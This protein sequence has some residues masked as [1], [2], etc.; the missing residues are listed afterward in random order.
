MT[1]FHE[2]Q[3]ATNEC[4]DWKRCHERGWQKHGEKNPSHVCTCIQENCSTRY[5]GKQGNYRQKGVA[6]KIPR[7][8][9]RELGCTIGIVDQRLTKVCAG[10]KP[11]EGTDAEQAWSSPSAEH[12]TVV[13]QAGGSCVS[14]YSKAESSPS[15]AYQQ[16][17]TCDFYHDGDIRETWVWWSALYPCLVIGF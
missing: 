7:Y 1:D 3:S 5:L 8:Y 17:E 4:C 2:S 14:Q 6:A 13:K 10:V 11:M 16:V 9:V 12:C 15:G